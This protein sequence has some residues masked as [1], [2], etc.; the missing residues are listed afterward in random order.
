MIVVDT[1]ALFAAMERAEPDHE[2][3]AALFRD[4]PDELIVP[5]SV[6]VESCLLYERR[7]GP[8]AESRFLHAIADSTMTVVPLSAPDL[9][10]MAD[11]I[12]RYGDL[13]LGAVD[14]SIVTVAERLGASSILT[15]DRR[16]FSVVRPAHT[17]AFTLLP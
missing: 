6:I 8:R 4:P 12:S 9:R 3:C 14:A 7:R 1:G 15:L 10:R 2:A 16:H 11:L 13:R 5:L 17:A